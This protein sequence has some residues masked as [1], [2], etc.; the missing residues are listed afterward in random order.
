MQITPGVYA[1]G[2]AACKDGVM[3]DAL[4]GIRVL[5]FTQ[6]WAGPTCARLL[7]DFGAEV[8]KVESETRPDLAR[9]VG[10]YP[11]NEFD[12]DASGYFVEWNRN[13]RS[14]RLNLREPEDVEIARRVA[15]TCDAVV[16]NFAPGV[17][18][19]LGLGYDELRVENPQ[20]VMLSLSGFGATGPLCRAPAFGQQIEAISGLMSVTGYEDGP[21]LK[22]GVSYPDPLSGIAGAAAVV[23]ALRERRKNGRGAWL[24]MSMLEITA[25]Q[26]SEP[27]VAAQLTGRAP[28]PRANASLRWAPHGIYR[29]AG[30][31]RWIA[32][33]CQDDV[34]WENLRRALGRPQSLEDD[35][36]VDASSRLRHREELDHAL[37]EVTGELPADTLA[38]DLQEHGVAAARAATIAELFH[39]EHLRDRGFWIP[40]EHANIGAIDTAGPMAVLSKTPARVRVQPALLGEHSEAIVAEL[41]AVEEARASDDYVRE[42][43]NGGDATQQPFRPLD[44]V[45][46]LELASEVAGPY[47]GKLLAGLG[48]DVIK[49]EFDAGDPMRGSSGEGSAVPDASRAAF[50]SLNAGKR[51]VQVDPC[52]KS[53]RQRLLQLIASADLIVEDLVPGK[54]EELA[55]DIWDQRP[56]LVVASITPFGKTG[57]RA[58]WRGSDLVCWASGGMAHVTGE[59][60]HAPL[61]VGSDQCAHLAGLQAVTGVLIA[62]HHR[63]ETGAGQRVDVSMEEA[64]ASILESTVTEYQLHD[65]V[66]GRMGTRHP[67]AHGVGMQRL[68]D[69]RWLFVGTCP[70]PRMWQACREIMGDPEWARDERWESYLERRVH[71][72][73][74]DALAAESF[75]KLTVEET[76]EPMLE[77]GIPVGL[78]YDALEVLELDQLEARG[79]FTTIV[80]PG[81]GSVRIPGT[82]WAA[83]V[84]GDPLDRAPNLGEHNAEI[85]RELETTRLAR[86]L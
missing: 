64:A 70:Q 25:S 68:A 35:R 85:E 28:G 61:Q 13:K 38:R 16:E 67:V 55:G 7:G 5:D 62:L 8:L 37:G 78:V 79:F 31:D 23:A 53:G 50:L 34:D 27:L 3:A 40:V 44:G 81:A 63:D 36:Y 15:A 59:P 69:G 86:Q 32:I 11:D 1:W 6:A 58:S 84:D 80:D 65:H 12:L 33:D 20:L 17:M 4:H 72:D 14:L 10:P 46:V 2:A 51:S 52:E 43:A 56:E 83:F 9:M 82:P 41:E 66:R 49:V 73:E 29:C 48:A 30:D 60:D 26:L 71:A 22:P 45:R 75:S 42:T 76:L 19:R 21:P 18:A 77:K 39:D 57:P 54:F 47:A 24:D 74:I